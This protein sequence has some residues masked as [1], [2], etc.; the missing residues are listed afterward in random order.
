[1]AIQV[2]FFKDQRGRV[3]SKEWL[4]A[5]PNRVQA[6]L[7]HALQRLQS[8]GHRIRRPHA[9]LLDDGIYELR[10]AYKRQQF[11]LLYFF[12]GEGSA[13]VTHGFV[14]ERVVPPIEIERA[15]KHRTQF[16]SDP[17]KFCA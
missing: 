16:R 1:M 17:L 2:R 10:V 3:P 8:E 5:Q 6:K 9:D 13:V 7:I 11:R 14:K 15:K 4:K 12:E